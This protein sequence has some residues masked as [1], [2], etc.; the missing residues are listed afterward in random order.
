MLSWLRRG[1]RWFDYNQLPPLNPLLKAPTVG[2][3]IGGELK[4]IN[5]VPTH[6]EKK[7]IFSR[8]FILYTKYDKELVV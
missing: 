2:P 6:P 8:C 4:E 5:P 7:P 1:Q 3:K